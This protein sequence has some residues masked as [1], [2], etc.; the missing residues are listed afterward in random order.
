MEHDELIRKLENLKAPEFEP[1]VYKQALKMALLNSKH[2]KKRTAAGWAKIL[3]P[4]TAAAVLV[5]TV[6]FPYVIQPQLLMAQS[7]ESVRSDPRF[8]ELKEL[9]KR[10]GCQEPDVEAFKPQNGVVSVFVTCKSAC[11]GGWVFNVT[12]E[13]GKVGEAR[14]LS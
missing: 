14:R 12:L 5:A 9:M 11:S 4:V 1:P 8:L 2:F 13:D 10:N 3:A 7:E 6:G